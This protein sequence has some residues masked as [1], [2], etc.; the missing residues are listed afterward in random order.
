MT[1]VVNRVLDILSER[2][3]LLRTEQSTIV[4][5]SSAP[6]GRSKRQHIIG[7]LVRTERDYVE[8]L[9]LLQQFKNNIEESGAIAGD[10]AHDIFLNLNALL[11]FQR[12]FLIRIEQQ[13]SLPESEQNWG[14]IF[15]LYKDSF[16]VY[17]PFLANQNRCTA[18]V[19]AE[20]EKIKSAP[21]S[22]EL[23]G[24]VETPT[25]LLAFLVKPFQ[26]LTKYPLLLEVCIERV[27]V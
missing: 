20:W 1:K 26:R 14:R 13:N 7:E 16:R 25:I 12:R 3:L 15:A 17:E 27:T 9:D 6:G 24:M 5:P 21:I 18:A 2:G 23:K 19:M 4:E 10:A 8:H 11:D 22:N